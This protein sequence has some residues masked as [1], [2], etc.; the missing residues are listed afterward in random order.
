MKRIL[1]DY[2]DVNI[3]RTVVMKPLNTTFDGLTYNQDVLVVCRIELPKFEKEKYTGIKLGMEYVAPVDVDLK[4][5]QIKNVDIY[6]DSVVRYEYKYNIENSNI[7][8]VT[9]LQNGTETDLTWLDLSK[10]KFT[11]ENNKMVAT[12]VIENNYNEADAIY[13]EREKTTYH[14]FV[15]S[16]DTTYTYEYRVE[17]HPQIF[18]ETIDTAE[19]ELTYVG[20]LNDISKLNSFSIGETGNIYINLCSKEI[21]YENSLLRENNDFFPYTHSVYFNKNS[22]FDFFYLNSTYECMG[23]N[24]YFLLISYSHK[25]FLSNID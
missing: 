2:S 18:R 22:V 7:F 21:F 9:V 24:H 12:F 25:I 5:Y 10:L 19:L 23:K 8:N 14:F 11:E 15:V 17:N 16:L 1:K 3:L 4:V 6:N 13:V 20:G